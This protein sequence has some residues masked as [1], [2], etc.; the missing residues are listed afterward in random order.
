LSKNAEKGELKNVYKDLAQAKASI[1]ELEALIASYTGLVNGFDAREYMESGEFA[2]QMMAYCEKLAVDVKGEHP[3]YEI[4]PYKVRI[5][6]DNQELYIDRKK[7]Q[8]LRP[9]YFVDSIKQSQ[10]K[11]HK[12]T[13]NANAFLNELAEAYDLALLKKEDS[14]KTGQRAKGGKREA[15]VFLKDL[16]SMVVPMQR[17]RKE[18]DAQSYAFDLTRLY[19][20]DINTTKDGRAFEF[21]TSRNA[22]KLIRIIDKDGKE[23]FLGTIRF[24]S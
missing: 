5:D 7:S 12:A 19:H 17:F 1:S 3:V 10:D 16:Y 22:S 18:Y 20:S 13:F 8:C 11:L 6:S 4:F 24:Y 9:K 14:G 15:D 23:Q 21:G 2:Q